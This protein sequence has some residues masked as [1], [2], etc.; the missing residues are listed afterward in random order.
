MRG[1]S[2]WRWSVLKFATTSPLALRTEFTSSGESRS[3]L[4]ANDV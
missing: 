2:T 1:S 3:P 4:L